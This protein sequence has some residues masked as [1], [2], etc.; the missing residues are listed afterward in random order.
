MTTQLCECDDWGCTEV[1]TFSIEAIM[2]IREDPRNILISKACKVG[3]K[4]TDVLVD[5]GSNFWL[6]RAGD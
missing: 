6:Y 1:V 4:P 2:E 3:P 5:E